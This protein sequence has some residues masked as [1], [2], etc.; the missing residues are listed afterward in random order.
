M[1][2]KNLTDFADVTHVVPGIHP[3]ISI[4]DKEMPMHSVEFAESTLTPS[5]DEGLMIGVKSLSIAT[6]EILTDPELL[7]EI[8]SEFEE[9]RLQ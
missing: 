1:D 6:V 4:T 9:K 3:M 2:T 7:A 8:K 5:G